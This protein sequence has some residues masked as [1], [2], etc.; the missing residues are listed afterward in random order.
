MSKTT[1]EWCDYSINP[2]KGLCPM[3][4]SYCYA[5]RLYKRFKWN[6]EIRWDSEGYGKND[7]GIADI[8]KPSRIFV[9]ST[10]E[11]FG[12]WVPDRII[13]TLL[14][15]ARRYTQHTFI[16]LTKKPENLVQ[17]SPFPE[18][19]WVGLS[20][21]GIGN[22]PLHR[23]YNGLA[24]IQAKVKFISFEPLLADPQLDKRDMEW[25][26]INWLIIGQQTP[27]SKKTQPQVSWIKETV[28]AA[29]KAST[30]VFLKE[31]LYPIFKSEY[32]FAV[33]KWASADYGINML[34]QE[35]PGD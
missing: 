23:I 2:V 20:V 17:W 15:V 30:P 10:M 33:P 3:A 1:I 9:G 11:L 16:F 34:R 4:C 28:E 14:Q 13:S 18:N 5:R 22:A 8:K 7:F 24:R 31:N 35:L 19:C 26:G 25:A 12:A 32:G 6:P 21:D 29:D 27:S